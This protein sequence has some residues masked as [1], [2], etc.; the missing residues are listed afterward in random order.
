MRRVSNRTA[1]RSALKTNAFIESAECFNAL[2]GA[3][4][5]LQADCRRLQEFDDAHDVSGLSD[6]EIERRQ[7]LDRIPQEVEELARF[8]TAIS[9]SET[10][11][12][13]LAKV[14]LEALRVR[15]SGKAEQKTVG[16]GEPEL[17]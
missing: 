10:W 14:R 9:G 2:A 4:D 6:T 13:A 1:L 8:T 3:L 7:L 15:L 5:T 16:Y 12:D 11:E 17:C